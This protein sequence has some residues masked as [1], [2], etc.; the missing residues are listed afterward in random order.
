[1]KRSFFM[2]GCM[3]ASMAAAQDYYDYG[4]YGESD[5]AH[6]GYGYFE[7]PSDYS[8][9]GGGYVGLAYASQVYPDYL[10]REIS[11][12]ER[13]LSQETP[14]A[15]GRYNEVT[16]RFGPQWS[17]YFR[18]QMIAAMPRYRVMPGPDS[19]EARQMLVDMAGHALRRHNTLVADRLLE[20]YELRAMGRL[21]QQGVPPTLVAAQLREMDARRRAFEPTPEVPPEPNSIVKVATFRN[22]EGFTL[23]SG[24]APKVL[25]TLTF[26]PDNPRNFIL[27]VSLRATLERLDD[28]PSTTAFGLDIEVTPQAPDGPE[29]AAG[30]TLYMLG[31]DPRTLRKGASSR[32]SGEAET[33]FGGLHDQ[34]TYTFYLVA[35]DKTLGSNVRVRDIISRVYYVSGFV[36]AGTFE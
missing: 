7:Q 11:R 24:A 19:P 36:E 2:L 26:V 9:G 1:M 6:Y 13:S 22:T 21:S 4:G 12:L 3:V 33:I 20:L 31:G 25:D 16:A 10:D 14:F 28:A 8:S 34:A 30:P 17:P 29:R 15:T 35:P 32:F 18:E 23:Q 5:S 27:M